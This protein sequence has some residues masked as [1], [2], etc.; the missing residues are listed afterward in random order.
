MSSRQGL[1]VTIRNLLLRSFTQSKSDEEKLAIAAFWA[2]FA[3]QNFTGFWREPEL[4]KFFSSFARKHFSRFATA[5]STKSEHV[6]V[7]VVTRTYQT[8]GH[9]RF[10]ENLIRLDKG[11]IHHLIVLDQGSIEP[12]A[13]L[14]ELIE[15]QRGELTYLNSGSIIQRGEELLELITHHGGTVMLHQHPDDILPSLTLPVL[16]ES[17]RILFF[18]H[19]D[20]CFSL[21]IETAHEVINIRQ[22]AHNITVYG[23]EKPESYLLPIPIL[24]PPFDASLMPE[25]RRKWKIDPGQKIG[26]CI[27]N[28][29]KFIPSGKHHF[30]R[31]MQKALAQNPELVILVVGVTPESA[32]H[33]E[34]G[35]F[36]HE[37]LFLLGP[38]NDPT[39]LQQIADIAI[40]PM[41]MGSY[42]A[43]LETCSFSAIPLV[44]YDTVP[45]FDL[46]NDPSFSGLFTST[47]TEDDYLQELKKFVRH[48]DAPM[49]EQI[50]IRIE[51]EHGHDTWTNTWL[52]IIQKTAAIPPSTA[53]NKMNALVGLAQ[54]EQEMKYSLLSWL[55]A[56]CPQLRLPVV[57]SILFEL[58]RKDFPKR[59]LAGIL[60]KRFLQT[61][62]TR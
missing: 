61:N 47:N 17:F 37:R 49:R 22:E 34:L 3:S 12:R 40:D 33:F 5:E 18:N 38:I 48:S 62:G 42:T 20:H 6:L 45:L 58:C 11:R 52:Q 1:I 53:P 2:S 51:K 23:R 26:L 13:I 57:L 32:T 14:E 27:G 16:H 56:S 29:K 54:S 10:L 55:Y 46:Y 9:S 50:R 44:C 4:E 25:I 43:L 36:A 7:H 15:Q 31:T 60:K 21:G 59:E 30:F 8:G 28:P 24:K 19:A 35:D 39:E 41:P